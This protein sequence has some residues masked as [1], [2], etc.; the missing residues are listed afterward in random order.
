MESHYFTSLTS[1]ALWTLVLVILPVVVPALIVGLA[2][3]MFQAA[4]SINEMT[5][6]FVPKLLVVL[7]SLFLFGTLMM[8][9][10]G[11]FLMRIFDR[12]PDLVR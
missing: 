3:G 12:I 9:W 5:L 10:L 2:L 6:S 7:L 11:D 1:E 8:Q 4:T